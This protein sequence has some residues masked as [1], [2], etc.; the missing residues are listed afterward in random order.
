MIPRNELPTEKIPDGADERPS[1]PGSHLRWEFLMNS[2]DLGKAIHD[3]VKPEKQGDEPSMIAETANEVGKAVLGEYLELVKEVGVSLIPFGKV[4]GILWKVRTIVKN[5]KLKAQA[6]IDKARNLIG[7]KL[8]AEVMDQRGKTVD[9]GIEPRVLAF[10][11]R[12]PGTEFTSDDPLERHYA[13]LMKT[14]DILDGIEE[15]VTKGEAAVAKAEALPDEEKEK[16]ARDMQEALKGSLAGEKS[17]RVSDDLLAHVPVAEVHP[18]EIQ[19]T[20]VGM[21][22]AAMGAPKGAATEK[23]S[24]ARENF[25]MAKRINHDNPVSLSNRL[26][27]SLLTLIDPSMITPASR[28]DNLV[29]D[30]QEKFQAINGTVD[31]GQNGTVT[32]K[33]VVLDSMNNWCNQRYSQIVI[34]KGADTFVV[35][36]GYFKLNGKWLDYHSENPEATVAASYMFDAWEAIIDAKEKPTQAPAN[37]D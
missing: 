22:K 2:Y 6:E 32:F 19:Q 7:T 15:K 3:L 33:N 9:A 5:A 36:G 23:K 24:A 29:E 31:L 35:D 1:T 14:M 4:L 10:L 17:M 25:E 13:A 8:F 34:Q 20:T 11:G 27:S 26:P 18:D 21:A 16:L 30:P 37:H 28:P 12:T